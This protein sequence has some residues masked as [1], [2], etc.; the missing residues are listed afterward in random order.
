MA[1]A[2]RTSAARYEE[3]LLEIGTMCILG[4]CGKPKFGSHSV[5]KTEP[6]KNL[7]SV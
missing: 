2:S 4:M 3:H 5:L 6:S 7:I 1:A